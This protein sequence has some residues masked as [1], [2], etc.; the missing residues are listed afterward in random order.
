MKGTYEGE[1]NKTGF[2]ILRTVFK[3]LIKV[4][5]SSRKKKTPRILRLSKKNESITVFYFY[6]SIDKL[7][8]GGYFMGGKKYFRKKNPTKTLYIYKEKLI[9]QLL[10]FRIPYTQKKH[11]HIE[12]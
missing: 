1:Q 12:N 9:I 3:K 7:F 6:L 10:D 5:L 4:F 2:L 11:N 8:L